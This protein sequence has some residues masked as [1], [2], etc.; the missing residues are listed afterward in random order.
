MKRIFK[1]KQSAL[2]LSTII[3]ISN[4][5]SPPSSPAPTPVKEIV[6]NNE[7]IT[8]IAKVPPDEVVINSID[9]NRYSMIIQ[10][11]ASKDYDFG[12]Y[13][14]M[15][16]RDDSTIIDTLSIKQ[17]VNDTVFVL[18]QFDPTIT[19]WFWIIVENNSGLRTEGVRSTHELE[20][21]PPTKTTILPIEFDEQLKIRWMRNHDHDFYAYE[22]YQS[23]VTDMSGR[24]KLK[25][26]ESNN[27][28][29]FVLPMDNTYFYQIVIKDYW[30]LES[31]S[32]VIKGDYLIEIWNKEYSILSTK[33][34]DLSSMKLFGEIPSELGLLANLEILRLQNNFLNGG[35]PDSFWN[36]K[37]LRLLNLSNNHLTGSIH[38]KINEL[39]SLEELWLSRNQ[40]SG[41]LPYQIYLLSNLTHLNISENHITGNLSESISKLSKLEYLNLW[42]NQLSGFIPPDIGS[43]SK[44]EFLSLGGNQLVGDIPQEIGNAKR[45]KSIALFENNLSGAIPTSLTRLPELQYLGLFDNNFRGNISNNLMNTLDLSYL[46]LNKNRFNTINQDSMCTSGY[47]WRNFIFYDVSDNR[48]ENPSICFQTDEILKIQSSVQK[49]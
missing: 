17:D 47:D 11:D 49:K 9:Y 3:I 31:Y 28:T 21:I 7:P 44:L 34:I 16:S 48:F 43:L 20:T 32:N 2:F 30:G 29:L 33:E 38:D 8:D 41:D 18:E 36:L 35:F 15:S 23:L 24:I 46:R 42:N 26:L 10:W 4:C 14:L 5:A 37:K 12:K 19:N 22:V 45:L 6:I 1:I 13:F 40:F 25:T 27:D 39:V